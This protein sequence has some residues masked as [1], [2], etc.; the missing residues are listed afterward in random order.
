MNTSDGESLLYAGFWPRLGALLLDLLI[1]LPLTALYFWGDAHYRLFNLYCLVPSTLFG[2]F[3]GVFLVRRFGGTP[4]K[5]ITG[6]RIRKINGDPVGYREA[7]LRYF[8]EFILGLLIAVALLI[9]KVN[10]SDAEYEAL[11][12]MDRAKRLT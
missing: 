5:L 4:G 8:P 10:M 7:F 6:I 9:P 11:S 1:I 12:F 2:L 3:Y